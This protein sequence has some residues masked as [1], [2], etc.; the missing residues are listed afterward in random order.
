LFASGAAVRI[1][2]IAF[3][4]SGDQLLRA[5]RQRPRHGRAAKKCDEF[6]SPHRPSPLAQTLGKLRLSH[7]GE[8]PLV[9]NGKLWRPMSQLGQ[10][11]PP[12][13][14]GTLGGSL[15]SATTRTGGKTTQSTTSKSTVMLRSNDRAK[16]MAS[17][18]FASAMRVPSVQ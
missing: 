18:L 8:T 11:L 15:R 4:V 17:L 16:A 12:C 5:R 14:Y 9:H 6:P 10:K 2:L 1:E 7:S 13:T 3:R